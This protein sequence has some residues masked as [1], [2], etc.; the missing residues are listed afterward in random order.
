MEEIF[1]RL[2]DRLYDKNKTL[3]IDEA[4]T[5]VELLW[6]DFETTRAKAGRKYKGKEMTEQIVIRWIDH[7]GPK[8]HDFIDNNPKYK[9]M[10][11][12][13]NQQLH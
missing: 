5:W 11:D 3:T 6:E 4:R 9:K 7:Y 10:F 12:Q 8:L 2:A 1:E 13:E